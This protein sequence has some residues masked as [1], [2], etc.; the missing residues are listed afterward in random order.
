MFAGRLRVRFGYTS[1]FE[2]L[3][4]LIVNWNVRDKLRTCLAALHAHPVTLQPQEIIVVDNASGD[5]SVAM[6]R[7]EFPGVELIANETNR[8]FTGGN[9]DGLRRVRELWSTRVA[10]RQGQLSD[11]RS[12]DFV[13]LLNPDTEVASGAL[14]ELLGLALADAGIGVVGPQLRYPDGSV[15]SSRRRFPTLELAMVESTWAQDRAPRALLDHYYVRDRGDDETSD[16]DWLVGAALLVRRGAVEAVGDLDEAR[17]FM[18]SE[19]L[20]WCKRIRDA[21]WRVVYHPRARVLHYEGASSAQVSTQRMIYFNTSKVRYFEKHHGQAA[22]ETLR[23]ALL[24]QFRKQR[25]LEQ[26]KAALGHKR[27]LRRERIAA[28]TAVIESG[29]R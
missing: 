7:A 22:A 14:D 11:A 27:A 2:M 6:V 26:V 23:A 21:G 29:L 13:L 10:A 18:Y 16:V 25:T 5:D 15:Q 17:F 28:Y 8:G 19:E 24:A 20:D 4:I 9:N 3:C 1:A 12:D